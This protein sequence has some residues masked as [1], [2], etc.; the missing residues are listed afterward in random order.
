MIYETPYVC[1]C[2]WEKS[3][4]KAPIAMVVAISSLMVVGAYAI[5][6]AVARKFP[7]VPAYY[8]LSPGIF[9][10]AATY[11]TGSA[12]PFTL[13]QSKEEAIAALDHYGRDFILPMRMPRHL[14]EEAYFTRVRTISPRISPLLMT[15]DTWRVSFRE[16][17]ATVVYEVRFRQGRSDRV[18]LLSTLVA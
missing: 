15:N 2:E 5:R 10:Y 14:L 1:Q 8:S 11:T 18:Q 6:G 17:G 4:V 9:T 16:Q 3:L 13:G 12:G 7:G